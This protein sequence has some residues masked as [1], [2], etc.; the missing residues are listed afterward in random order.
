VDKG[1]GAC[2]QKRSPVL[3]D[4]RSVLIGH[5]PLDD[6]FQGSQLSTWRRKHGR[7]NLGAC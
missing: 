2:S 7:P 6:A 3:A 5:S 4:S 1:E